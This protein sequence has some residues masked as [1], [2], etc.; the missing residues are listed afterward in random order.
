M[1]V[2]RAVTEL[3]F[4]LAQS[5]NI[6]LI[7]RM[8]MCGRQ[9]NGEGLPPVSRHHMSDHSDHVKITPHISSHHIPPSPRDEHPTCSEEESSQGSLYS[10]VHEEQCFSSLLHGSDPS[11]P[12]CFSSMDCCFDITKHSLCFLLCSPSASDLPLRPLSCGAQSLVLFS[13]EEPLGS[14]YPCNCLL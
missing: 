1:C 2:A 9:S 5:L 12:L 11:E 10:M 7:F 4:N 14:V 13:L 8:S 6:Y 3:Q